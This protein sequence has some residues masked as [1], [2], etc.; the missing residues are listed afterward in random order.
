MRPCKIWDKK[1]SARLSR[2]T[3]PAPPWLPTC[4][5]SGPAPFRHL[6]YPLPEPNQAGLG[7][8]ATLDLAGQVS[9]GSLAADA[10]TASA[11]AAAV[12]CDISASAP[13]GVIFKPAEPRTRSSSLFLLANELH[14]R[15][16][17]EGYALSQYSPLFS[18]F[19]SSSSTKPY[20]AAVF[21][22]LCTSTFTVRGIPS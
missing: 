16:T 5:F 11:S 9:A 18:A 12:A 10:P 7:V 19:W 14:D 15:S 22:E 3:I 2:H 17:C 8:H 20:S 4:L 1:R 6:V 13:L 21:H